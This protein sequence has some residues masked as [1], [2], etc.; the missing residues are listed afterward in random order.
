MASN[1]IRMLFLID[2]VI[3]K[4]VGATEGTPWK[5]DTTA[6]LVKGPDPEEVL[7]LIRML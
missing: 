4:L 5:V 7:A 1:L 6:D 3:T 2:D